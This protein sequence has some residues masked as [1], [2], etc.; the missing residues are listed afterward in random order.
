MSI[1]VE[2]DKDG[3][4]FITLGEHEM[5][6]DLEDI[7]GEFVERARTELLET[8]ERVQEGLERF[9][10]LIKGKFMIFMR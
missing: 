4:P 10:E 8:P 7:S 2:T 3:I 1:R 9:R 5:R 6:L